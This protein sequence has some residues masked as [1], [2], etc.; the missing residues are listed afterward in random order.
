[1]KPI[2]IKLTKEQSDK[3][4][5]LFERADKMSA[6]KRTKGVILAQI[7]RYPK[8]EIGEAVVHFVPHAKALA[9]QQILIGIK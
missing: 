9:I 3:L 5:S 7:W 1:M 2:K 6:R 4:E 8:C